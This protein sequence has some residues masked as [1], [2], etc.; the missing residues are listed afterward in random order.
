MSWRMRGATMWPAFIAATLA[1]GVLFDVRPFTGDG[2][3][4]LVPALLLAVAFNLVVVAAL[5]PLAGFA[6][7]RRRRDLPRAIA[8]DITGTVLVGVLFAALLAG[9]LV[10]HG[11]LARED[12]DRAAAYAATSTYVHS[13]AREYLARL[14]AMDAV[15]VEPGMFRTCVPDGHDP[16]KPLCFF[17]NV[18]QSPPG[19][20]RDHDRIPNALWRR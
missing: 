6:L 12:R 18:D 10:H 5:A 13:Q 8:T 14:D 20:T 11:A 9:G 19:V 7:R 1:E 3:G 4:G 15:R 16:M 17:V 2:P